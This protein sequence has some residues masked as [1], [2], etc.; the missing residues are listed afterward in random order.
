MSI[1]Y[2]GIAVATRSD[3]GE[4]FPLAS[5]VRTIAGTPA[6][7]APEMLDPSQTPLGPWT[8]IY[9]LGAVLYELLTQRPPHEAES[10]ME[11]VQ[12]ILRGPAL[13][14]HEP[15]LV[16]ICERAMQLDPDARFESALQFRLAVQGYLRHEGARAIAKKADEAFDTWRQLR[17]DGE[18]TAADATS[19]KTRFG[20][21]AA[22]DA[23]PDFDHAKAKLR[24]LDLELA[25]AELDAGNLESA[26]R[27]LARVKSPPPALLAK[28]RAE[29][30]VQRETEQRRERLDTHANEATNR[31]TRAVFSAFVGAIGIAGPLYRSVFVEATPLGIVAPY[32][33]T[34]IFAVVG[35]M[36][37]RRALMHSYVNRALVTVILGT[38]VGN[39]SL[40]LMAFRYE[41]GSLW[42]FQTLPIVWAAAATIAVGTVSRR[43]WP[44]A[45]AMT[46]LCFAA[47]EEPQWV[48]GL[49]S[50]ANAILFLNAVWV[51]R[52]WSELQKRFARPSLADDS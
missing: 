32:L 37:M 17:L 10:M 20:Y 8:D 35:A 15:E 28:V 14:D 5:E 30:Q 31:G 46:V 1:S 33:A 42:L 45:L 26:R 6:Y 16:H 25:Q 2:W 52:S 24:A 41:L 11:L 19:T 13:P 27:T 21:Q 4:H 23:W 48:D 18:T 49:T 3:V 38:V 22:L 43:F 40:S 12:N 50:A 44:T 29:E 9:L 47:R 51:N 7:M 34:L 39:L 36:L